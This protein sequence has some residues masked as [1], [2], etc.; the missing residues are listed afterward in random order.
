MLAWGIQS[1]FWTDGVA[2]SFSWNW[3][4]QSITWYVNASDQT[5]YGNGSNYRLVYDSTQNTYDIGDANNNQMSY[6]I[7]EY[8]G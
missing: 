2:S 8:Q 1:H 7:C 6:Y 3:S 5:I 4:N